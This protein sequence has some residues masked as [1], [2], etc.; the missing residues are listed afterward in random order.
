M[1]CPMGTSTPLLVRTLRRTKGRYF[2]AAE[3]WRGSPSVNLQ[4]RA[5]IL[6]PPN[7]LFVADRTV[8]RSRVLVDRYFRNTRSSDGSIFLWLARKSGQGRGSGWPAFGLTW[9]RLRTPATASS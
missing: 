1:F 3:S 9:C 8:P 2:C 7:P 5:V 6:D 4:A